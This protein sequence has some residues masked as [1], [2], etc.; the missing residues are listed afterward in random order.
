MDVGHGHRRLDDAR[1]GRHV[2]ELLEGSVLLDR[3]QQLGVGEHPGR[4]A[5]ARPRALRDLPELVVEPLDR[6]VR[7]RAP[8]LRNTPNRRA[9]S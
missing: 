8:L 7:H 1:Q 3:G 4:D 9:Q 5:H 2:G 6:K